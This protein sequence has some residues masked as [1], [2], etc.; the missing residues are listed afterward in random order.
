VVE[1]GRTLGERLL[2]QRR[3]MLRGDDVATLQRHLGSL[4]FDAGRVDGIFGPQTHAALVDFQRN[5]GLTVDGICGPATLQALARV[6]GKAEE[7]VVAG[8]RERERLRD[9][10]PTLRGQRIVVG[11]PGGLA[12]LADATSR[13]LARIGASVVTLHDPDESTQAGQAN[14]L[15]AAVYV[16]LRL[17]PDRCGC[18]SAFFRGH[19]GFESEGGR[20]LADAV[21]Q[22]LPRVL[23]IPDLGTQGMAL[24][25][26]RETRMTAVVVELGPP[27][28]AVEHG[29]EVGQ[30]LSRALASWASALCAE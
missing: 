20:R 5:A 28:V 11:E 24:P 26:L 6:G 19:R 23:G 1:A 14:D 22:V 13:I 4:G 27:R 7:A 17:D 21:Q 2:Y 18:A 15:G 30:G 29:A 25:V 9:A 3:P 12:A 16:G 8:V 10:P